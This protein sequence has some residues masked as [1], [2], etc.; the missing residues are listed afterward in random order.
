MKVFTVQ[1]FELPYNNPDT[2]LEHRH[3]TV[4]GV[5]GSIGKGEVA[6]WARQQKSGPEIRRG[7]FP[8]MHGYQCHP[9]VFG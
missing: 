8:G 2:G 1:P 6:K 4:P 3:A 7:S 9:T 5:A